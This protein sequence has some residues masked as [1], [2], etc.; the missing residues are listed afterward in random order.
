MAFRDEDVSFS[1]EV[2]VEKAYED[3]RRLQTI[4]FRTLGM[5]KRLS[6]SEAIGDAIT[7]MQRAIAIMNQLRL[8]MAALQAARMAAGDPLAWA[9]FAIAGGGFLMSA[10]DVMMD[11]G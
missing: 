5:F 10:G 9:T 11:L 8:A 1:M 3:V 4:L 6:G 2:N 7:Q